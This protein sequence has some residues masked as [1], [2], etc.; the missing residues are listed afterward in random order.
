MACGLIGCSAP[1]GTDT[2]SAT[3]TNVAANLAPELRPA[4]CREWAAVAATI[5][6][7]VQVMETIDPNQYA[8]AI[9][10]QRE[11]GA[12]SS[13]A[14][15]GL[16]ASVSNAETYLRAAQLS[17]TSEVVVSASGASKDAIVGMCEQAVTR[18]LNKTQ[19]SDP[20]GLIFSDK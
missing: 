11:L 8:T 20:G 2:G 17:A 14:G 13:N 5:G 9:A 15:S 10:D 19:E 18:D 6:C 3:T 12:A 4:S 1:E 7:S 16:C